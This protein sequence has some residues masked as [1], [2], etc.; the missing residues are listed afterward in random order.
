MREGISVFVYNRAYDRTNSA[1]AQSAWNFVALEK[2]GHYPY[3]EQSERYFQCLDEFL[4]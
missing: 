2:C 4:R 3:V 1:F